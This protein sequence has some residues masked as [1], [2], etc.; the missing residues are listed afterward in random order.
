MGP[1]YAFKNS[2]FAQ[3]FGDQTQ[4]PHTHATCSELHRATVTY[5]LTKH[6]WQ[7]KIN[8]LSLNSWIWPFNF[9]LWQSKNRGE[10][11]QLL[12]KPQR[13]MQELWA[14]LSKHQ[15]TVATWEFCLD[16]SFHIWMHR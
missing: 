7:V 2:T 13:N 10:H 9:G 4:D 8:P 1:S 16:T 12:V 6:A 5:F 15:V 11:C 3:I 14:R